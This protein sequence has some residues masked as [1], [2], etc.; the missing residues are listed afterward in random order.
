MHAPLYST[1]TLLAELGISAIIYYTL[2]QGYTHN[3]FPTLLAGFAL[4]YETIFNISYMVSRVP[5][6]AKALHVDYPIIIALAIVHGVLSLIMFIALI[7]F[8]IIAWTRYKKDVNYFQNHKVLT[9][10]FLFFWTFS[11][12]SGVLFYFLEYVF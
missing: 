11:I 3:K 6:H 12:V 7:I 9:M 8:F 10:V 4:L 1:I 5:T 2:Y